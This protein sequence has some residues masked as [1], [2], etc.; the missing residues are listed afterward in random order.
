MISRLVFDMF[1]SKE[2]YWDMRGDS[3]CSGKASAA[4]K[5]YCVQGSDEMNACFFLYACGCQRWV[6][7]IVEDTV[8][9]STGWMLILGV[10]GCGGGLSG[11]LGKGKDQREFKLTGIFFQ[12]DLPFTKG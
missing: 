2:K 6:D 5:E 11:I 1:C 3:A 4:E 8:G 12:K 9:I 7:D 10:R